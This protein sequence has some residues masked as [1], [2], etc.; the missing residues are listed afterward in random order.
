MNCHEFEFL[1]GGLLEGERHPEAAA[2][3]AACP[4]CRLLMD[5]LGAIERAA[6]RL[7]AFRATAEDFAVVV[8]FFPLDRRITFRSRTR[9]G[10]L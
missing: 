4:R 6:R 5:E 8:C 9:S 7:P 3:L 2:H 10:V 1:A